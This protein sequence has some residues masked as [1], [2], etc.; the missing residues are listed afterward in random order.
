M[1]CH[2]HRARLRGHCFSTLIS[3]ALSL[4]AAVA[5][6][7]LPDQPVTPPPEETSTRAD[8]S[9]VAEKSVVKIYSTVRYPDCFKPWGKQT[10]ASYIGSGVVIDGKRILTVA[11]VVSY[12]SQVQIE[13]NEAGDKL[14]ATV[15]AICPEMDLAVLQLEDDSF[16]DTHPPLNRATQLPQ[17]TDAVMV[18]G[19]PTGGSSMS[20]TKGIVSRIEFTTYN[21]AATGLRMQVDAAINPGNSGGPA[22]VGDS[23]VG[24]AFA[25]LSRAE[26]ISYIIPCEEIDLFLN[27]IS[28]GAYHGRPS[29]N[30][31]VDAL[32]NA[33]L[34]SFLGAD[35]T[36]HGVVVQRVGKVPPDSP[37]QK[38]DILTKIG[39]TEID[40]EGLV[41]LESGLR[42]GFTYMLQ[43][44]ATNGTVPLTVVRSGKLLR[45]QVPILVNPVRLLPALEGGYPDYFVYGPIVF[46]DASQELFTDLMVSRTWI[47]RLLDEGSPLV[48]RCDDFPEFDGERLVV[49]SSVFPHKLSRGYASPIA[50]VV[51]SVN[52]VPIRNLAHLVKV[53]RDCKDRFIT[54]DFFGRNTRTL[55]FLRQQMVEDT[56]DILTENSVRNQGSREMMAIW[57]QKKDE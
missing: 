44:L 22:V 48:T 33:A 54:V 52:G 57:N 21:Y 34:R 7:Q 29:L 23:M 5:P 1:K 13:A 31:T 26:N 15:E 50:E 39:H 42:V 53:L 36:V 38:W 3:L 14:N 11:H 47:G 30:V 40:D 27:A 9:D 20:I 49:V 12:A 2:L 51:K 56:D 8:K 45:L 6:A 10:P 19:F 55:V 17:T 18:Y 16:F 4:A 37:L 28:K 25:Q 35:N 46:S 43:Q 24:L 32:Q 41:R